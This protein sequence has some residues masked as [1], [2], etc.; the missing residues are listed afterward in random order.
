MLP[1]LE[2]AY[3]YAGKTIGIFLLLQIYAATFSFASISQHK[4]PKYTFI[5]DAFAQF[6]FGGEEFSDLF[7]Y[8]RGLGIRQVL[9]HQTREQLKTDESLKPIV[10]ITKGARTVVCL[11]LNPVDAS[12]MSSMFTE[13]K[14][15]PTNIYIH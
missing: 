12:E 2:D 5:I 3:K 14:R 9:T 13:L 7:N 10:G 4:R 8:G 1:L 15:R 6:A 11:N